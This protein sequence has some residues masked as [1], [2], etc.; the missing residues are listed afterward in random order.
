MKGNKITLNF[1]VKAWEA[2]LFSTVVNLMD[3][4]ANIII[5]SWL[6]EVEGHETVIKK[7]YNIT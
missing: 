2:G 7:T 5:K 1:R 3:I 4:R 6:I